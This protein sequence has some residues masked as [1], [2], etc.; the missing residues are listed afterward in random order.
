MSD[1]GGMEVTPEERRE[2]EEAL[3]EMESLDP[4]DLPDPAARLA[5]MLARLLDPTEE[6]S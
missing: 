6:P 3:A 4:A 1:N 5:G 2:L